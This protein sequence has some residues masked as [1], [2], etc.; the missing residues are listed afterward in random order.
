LVILILEILLS[1]HSITMPS[2]KEA[3]TPSGSTNP[4]QGG[5]KAPSGVSDIMAGP[6]AELDTSADMQTLIDD[7]TSQAMTK[8]LMSAMGLM[9]DSISQTLTHALIQVQKSTEP[10]SGQ[11]LPVTTPLQPQAGRKALAK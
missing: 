1:V 10:T 3:P 6:L 4:N 7:T 5:F 8:T 11:V 9:S 2:D